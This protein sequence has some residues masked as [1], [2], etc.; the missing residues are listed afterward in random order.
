MVLA[1][2]WTVLFVDQPRR[3]QYRMLLVHHIMSSTQNIV[4][5]EG[6]A[7]WDKVMSFD[8]VL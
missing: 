4:T 5:L 7:R 1:M 6:S 2:Q 8:H 3:H